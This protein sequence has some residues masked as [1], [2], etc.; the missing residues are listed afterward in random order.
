MSSKN[1]AYD[2]YWGDEKVRRWDKTVGFGK[3]KWNCGEKNEMKLGNGK[4]Q[5]SVVYIEI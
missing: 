2:Y 5:N 3:L 4:F 1:E